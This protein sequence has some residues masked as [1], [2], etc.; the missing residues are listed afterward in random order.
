MSVCRMDE[1]LESAAVAG[2][3]LAHKNRAECIL[4]HNGRRA[5]A[6]VSDHGQRG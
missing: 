4:M 2:H 6:T 1:A 3:L 5:V